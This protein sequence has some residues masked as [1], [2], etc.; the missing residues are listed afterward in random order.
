MQSHHGFYGF[1]SFGGPTLYWLLVVDRPWNF[2]SKE[3]AADLCGRW[4]LDWGAQ[5]SIEV[6]E[7]GYP[8]KWMVQNPI[9]S[10]YGIYANIWGILMVNVTIY[11][12]HGSYGNG[13]SYLQWIIWSVFLFSETLTWPGN[14]LVWKTILWYSIGFDVGFFMAVKLGFS[15]VFSR[16]NAREVSSGRRTIFSNGTSPCLEVYKSWLVVW[17]PSILFSH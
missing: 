9:G 15:I 7:N 12:I 13:T 14:C 10:M 4:R 3:R 5:K 6:S 11:G 8:I 16:A 2:V 17:L 1:L